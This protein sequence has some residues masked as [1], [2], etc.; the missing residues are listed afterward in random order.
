M[1]VGWSLNLGEGGGDH[2]LVQGS[3]RA[4][5]FPILLVFPDDDDELT[6]LRRKSRDASGGEVADT[7]CS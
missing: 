1:K 3:S 5:G 4:E 7:R 6:A 2:V